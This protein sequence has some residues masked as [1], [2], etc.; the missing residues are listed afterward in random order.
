MQVTL[1]IP[2]LFTTFSEIDATAIDDL[3]LVAFKKLLSRSKA[4]AAISTDY[5]AWLFQVFTGHDVP[6]SQI[7]FASLTATMDGLDGKNGFW[8]R[9]DPVY[10]YADTH[11]LILQDPGGLNLTFAERDE[12][13][14]VIRPL[15]DEYGATLHTPTAARWY[16]HFEHAAPQIECTPLYEALMKPANSYLPTGEDSRRWHTLFNE[17]QMV[18]NQST[19][20]ENRE[21]YGLQPVNSLWFWGLGASP[22]NPGAA[23]DCCIGGNDYVQALCRHTS[24][25]HK[26]LHEGITVSRYQDNALVLEDRLL[27]A[28]R[29]N[30]PEQWLKALQL[31]DQEVIAPLVAGLHQGDI[32]KL[33]LGTD[34]GQQFECSSVGI[35]KF[36]KR[37]RPL[38]AYL[39]D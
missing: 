20:N 6:A 8:M 2:A 3:N 23:F 19:V 27:T 36:W 29:L 26:L 30:S 35:R 39:L 34:N 24:N 17:I 4:L 28:Q 10:L 25:R 18:L 11:S 1:N 7:P 38:S 5:E 37:A 13:A 32:R 9:A 16:L 12:L 22:Q 33:F 15:F 31:A 14:D 21:Y